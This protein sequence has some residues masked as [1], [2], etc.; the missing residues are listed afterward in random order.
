[1]VIND[2][3]IVEQRPVVIGMEQNT[4]IGIKSG[5]QPGENI[6][7]AGLQKVRPGSPAKGVPPVHN[8]DSAGV[9]SIPPADTIPAVPANPP[10]ANNPMPEMKNNDVK[11]P[12][13]TAIPEKKEGA[14]ATKQRRL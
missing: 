5:L 9:T 8:N 11:E 14:E 7:T 12:A 10:A 4:D 13:A 6:I 1:M 2:K 3:G